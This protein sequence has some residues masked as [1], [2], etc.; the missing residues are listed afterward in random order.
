MVPPVTIGISQDCPVDSSKLLTATPAAVILTVIV[1]EVQTRATTE[2]LSYSSDC[3]AVIEP[4][5]TLLYALNLVDVL[6]VPE[7][8]NRLSVIPPTASEKS[9]V[10]GLSDVLNS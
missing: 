7:T 4:A 9:I 3:G 6:T 5:F 8:V 1:P 2:L 10:S